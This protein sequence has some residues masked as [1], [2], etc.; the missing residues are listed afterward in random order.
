MTTET[1]PAKSPFYKPEH[2][3][4]RTGVATVTGDAGGGG[5]ASLLPHAAR[6]WV[7]SS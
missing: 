2:L 5:A 4:F 3:A 1:P 7:I 6:A